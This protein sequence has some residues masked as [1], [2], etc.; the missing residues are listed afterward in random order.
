MTLP[1]WIP[2]ILLGG[3]VLSGCGGK[4]PLEREK[5]VYSAIGGSASL[6]VGA[7]PLSD[8]YT[9]RIQDELKDQGRNV[10]LFHIG[11]PGANTDIIASAVETAADNGM[12]AE[13]ATVWVGAHDLING[14]PVETFALALHS[15]LSSVQDEMEA[16][17]ILANIPSLPDLPN[18]IEEPLPEVN[19]ERVDQFNT[20]I[21]NQASARDIPVVDLANDAIIGNLVN[22]FDGIHPDDEGHERLSML[23]MNMIRPLL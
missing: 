3:L 8:G 13:L 23:F 10:A 1:S 11:L 9:F 2:V 17:V 4:A 12:E 15:L 6:G 18:F 14:V 19:A 21:K 16:Y 20:V 22:D 7:F 5:F